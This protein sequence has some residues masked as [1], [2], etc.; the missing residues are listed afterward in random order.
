MVTAITAH[1][2]TATFRANPQTEKSLLHSEAVER[3]L[4]IASSEM[5]SEEAF[6][7]LS[8]FSTCNCDLDVMMKRQW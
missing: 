1:S 8:G 2:A 3:R 5:S 6:C 4:D 7:I